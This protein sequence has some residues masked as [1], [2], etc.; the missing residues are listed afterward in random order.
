[1]MK[2]VDLCIRVGGIR[3][4]LGKL[5]IVWVRM[6]CDGCT[7]VIILCTILILVMVW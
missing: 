6:L 5:L 7:W 1:M 2:L 4:I 3:L